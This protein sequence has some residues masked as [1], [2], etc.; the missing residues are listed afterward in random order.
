M[1]R[2]YYAIKSYRFEKRI[3]IAFSLLQKFEFETFF[4]AFLEIWKL[5]RTTQRLSSDFHDLE[6]IENKFQIKFCGN[7]FSF[8]IN[9]NHIHRHKSYEAIPEHGA[10]N[11]IKTPHCSTG[12]A[13]EER[14]ADLERW[15][16]LSRLKADARDVRM[17]QKHKTEEKRIITPVIQKI[18]MKTARH[19][20]LN[21][22][23][24]GNWE[25][26]TKRQP[27]GK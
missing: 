8:V 14:N 27:V 7:V 11:Q 2:I 15:V 4:G 16:P 6:E 3:L 23:W 21:A 13:F 26:K 18:I 5:L 25:N 9:L 24:N 10:F 12:E 17:K 19:I 22:R 20:V 1:W